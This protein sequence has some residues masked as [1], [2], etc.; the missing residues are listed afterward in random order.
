MNFTTSLLGQIKT[1]AKMVV[2]GKNIANTIRIQTEKIK[3]SAIQAL[4]TASFWLGILAIIAAFIPVIGWIIAAVLGVVAAVLSVVANGIQAGIE[5]NTPQMASLNQSFVDST[6]MSEILDKFYGRTNEVPGPSET[7]EEKQLRETRMKERRLMEQLYNLRGSGM[8]NAGGGRVFADELMI[9]EIENSLKN[10]QE[11]QRNIYLMAKMTADILSTVAAEVSGG[12]KHFAA[13]AFTEG[14]IS[15]H[16]AAVDA[17]V[18]MLKFTLEQIEWANNLNIGVQNA[19]FQAWMNVGLSL[20]TMIPL[21]GS[22]LTNLITQSIDYAFNPNNARNIDTEKLRTGSQSTW[23]NISD[24]ELAALERSDNDSDREKAI[25][26][27]AARTNQLRDT[28]GRTILLQG[29]SSTS[30]GVDYGYFNTQQ[31]A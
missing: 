27:R 20:V 13:S 30:T 25:L 2:Q 19:R 29:D 15:T 5:Q 16:F 8:I 18:D 28:G 24:E 11:R 21:I 9:A 4:K 6:K 12:S 23:A 14:I 1:S 17:M 22:T 26:I 3:N 10:I 7:Q 31:K